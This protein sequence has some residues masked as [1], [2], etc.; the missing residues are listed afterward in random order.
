MTLE[1]RNE[2]LGHPIGVAVNFV[3]WPSRESIFMLKKGPDKYDAGRWGCPGGKQEYG[4]SLKEA[5]WREGREECGPGFSP[6]NLRYLGIVAIAQDVVEAIQKHYLCV[7]HMFAV[8][9]GCDPGLF[10]AEPGNHADVGWFP[11]TALPPN[12]TSAFREVAAAM[13]RPIGLGLA[14]PDVRRQAWGYAETEA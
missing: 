6:A 3:Y 4:E 12:V 11:L 1:R 2:H 13:T 7:I 5:A 9:E 8:H 10:N 14:H